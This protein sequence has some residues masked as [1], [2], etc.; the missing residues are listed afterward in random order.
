MSCRIA[1]TSTL[2]KQVDPIAVL[3]RV[4]NALLA[5]EDDPKLRV[6]RAVV[7]RGEAPELFRPSDDDRRGD[8]RE[9]RVVGSIGCREK[10]HDRVPHLEAQ[11]SHRRG[12]GRACT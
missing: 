9:R 5:T 8:G 3:Q 12:V 6:L 10:A 11:A 7:L 4:R 2:A 1:I